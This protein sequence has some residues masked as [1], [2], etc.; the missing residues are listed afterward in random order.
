MSPAEGSGERVSRTRETPVASRLV[1]SA[2]RTAPARSA[3]TLRTVAVF[4]PTIALLCVWTSYSEGVVS[5]T[6]FH[7]LSPPMN[8]VLALFF[9]AA[10]AVPVHHALRAGRRW[11]T[12]LLGLAL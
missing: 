12:L 6:S 11:A 2:D 7:S 8:I 3:F 1:P 10:V 4:L 5:S 9:L